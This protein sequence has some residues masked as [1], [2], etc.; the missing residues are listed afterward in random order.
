MAMR[1]QGN[2]V[3]KLVRCALLLC[4]A[5]VL[6]YLEN[7]VVLRFALLPFMKLGLANIVVTLAFFELS[8]AEAFAV[9]AMRVIIMGILFGSIISF[10]YSAL[11]ALFAF[12]GLFIARAI[13]KRVSYV[14]T[15]VVCACF[16]NFG[17]A[18]V[19]ALFF[20]IRVASFYLPYLL[21]CGAVFGTF[22]GVLL[23]FISQKYKKVISK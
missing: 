9:S 7:V 5:L 1:L 20:G 2:N 21:I 10:C 4:I 11:G 16:H 14:G 8:R 18:L 19:A 15:C 3:R 22:T 6:S 12:G 17:Q 13:G 23:N